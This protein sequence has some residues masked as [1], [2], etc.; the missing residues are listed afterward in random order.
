MK[1][2]ENLLLGHPELSMVRVRPLEISQFLVR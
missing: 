1:G 2:R